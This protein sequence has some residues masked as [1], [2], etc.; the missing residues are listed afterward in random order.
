MADQLRLALSALTVCCALGAGAG[1]ACADENLEVGY[2]GLT[3]STDNLELVLGGRLHLDAAQIDDTGLSLDDEEIRRA[4]LELSVRFFEDWRL[5]VDREFARGGG[6][7]NVWLGYEVDRALTL[8]A[9]NFIVPFSM[10]D[11]GSSNETMFM[12]RSLAQALAPGFGVGVAAIYEARRFVISGGYIGD[13]I[14]VEDNVQAEKGRGVAARATWSPLERRRQVLHLGLGLEHR[15]LDAGALRRIASGPEASLGPSVVT[16]GNIADVDHSMSYNVEAAY[17]FG[18]VLVQG[19]FIST[20]LSRDLGGDV[21]LSGYYL[22]AGWIVT[23]ERYRYGDR[24]G[25]F[26]GPRPQAPWGAVEL[27]A[28]VSELDLSEGV[29]SRSGQANDYTLGANW[30][31]GRNFRLMGNYVHSEVDA[32]DPARD[33]DVDVVEARAQFDF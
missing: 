24:A 27:A 15:D 32:A 12:E 11:I 28:R 33:R 29:S 8:K 17:S 3:Y 21:A 6:W 19:Q 14:D 1:G 4:R 20:D 30:Y 18:S 5:R 31:L 10:E 2:H 25:V 23:G 16:T 7:R 9:G 22:Q 26:A 13:A